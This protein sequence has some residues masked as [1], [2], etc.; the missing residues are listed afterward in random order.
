[1]GGGGSGGGGGGRSRRT[2]PVNGLP[3]NVVPEI[4]TSR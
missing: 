4:C 1:M 3:G 2:M